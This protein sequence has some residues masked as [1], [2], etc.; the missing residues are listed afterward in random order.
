MAGQLG[1]YTCE[2]CP[3]DCSVQQAPVFSINGCVDAITLYES[4]ISKIHFVGVSE[5]D[6]TEPITKPVDWTSAANWAT[7]LDNEA[8]DKI[9]SINVIGDMPEPEQ[10]IITMSGGREKV[11]AKTF[12]VNFDIDEFNATNYTAMRELECGFTG[13]F[14]FE[15]KGGL[16]FGGPKGIKATVVKA[17]TIHERGENLYQKILCQ[18]KWKSNCSPAMIVSPIVAGTC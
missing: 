9:R 13:F 3:E 15:T 1:L 2:T 4:E 14:W 8:D 16:L 5:E 11:G 12:I 6:C 10:Q 17:N 18:L 7:E